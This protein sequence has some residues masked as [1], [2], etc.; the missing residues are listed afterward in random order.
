MPETFVVDTNVVLVA[1]G[2]HGEVSPS[3]VATCALKLKAIMDSGRIALDNGYEVIREYQNKTNPTN[4]EKGPG[5]VFVKWALN[6]LT[7]PNRCDLVHLERVNGD[8]YAT[9]PH[10][11]DLSGFDT[12]DKKFVAVSNAHKDHPAILEAADSKWLD[13]APALKSCGIEV[14]FLCKEDIRRFHKKKFGS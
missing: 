1:G 8:E 4:L 13:W 9:F 11:P 12:A 10:H 6:N 14:E 2:R 7:N 5:E 3:C